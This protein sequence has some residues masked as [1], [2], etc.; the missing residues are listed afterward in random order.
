MNI[1]IIKELI[2]KSAIFVLSIT[3]PPPQRIIQIAIQFL[4]QDPVSNIQLGIN[5]PIAP[6]KISIT[7][8]IIMV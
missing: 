1:P 6:Q 8:S 2:K 7:P 5:T 3:N 4:L